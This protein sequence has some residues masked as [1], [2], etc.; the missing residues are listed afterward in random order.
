VPPVRETVPEPAAA[1]TVPPQVF[2]KALGFATTRLAGK[3]SV[4]PT[5]LSCTVFDP[6]LEM[7][8]VRVVA[9]PGAMLM[10]LNDLVIAAGPT[11]VS[12]A[13]LLAAPVP[14]S[15]EAIA[16]VVLSFVP[17]VIPV[18]VTEKVQEDPAAGEAVNVPPVRPTLPLPAVAVMIPLPH[19]P[20]TFGVAATTN[21]AGKL[22]ANPTPLRPVVVFGLLIVKLNVLLEFNGM[23]VGLNDLVSVGLTGSGFTVTVV[24]AEG[25]LVQPLVVAVTV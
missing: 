9:P 25:A 2:V 22:S 21:P 20:V 18:T 14:T 3:L 23:L 7:L 16:L 13:V 5:P 11:T 6:G 15:V 4:N 12:P 19:E 1:V 24:A 8:T 17:A 10:G